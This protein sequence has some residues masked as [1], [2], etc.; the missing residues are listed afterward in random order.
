MSKNGKDRVEGMNS[1]SKREADASHERVVQAMPMTKTNKSL[2][3]ESRSLAGHTEA[4][5]C[6]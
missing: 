5:V 6:W 4:E 3:I 2:T 1:H